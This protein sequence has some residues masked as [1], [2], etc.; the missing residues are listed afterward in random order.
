MVSEMEFATQI[1]VIWCMIL[2]SSGVINCGYSLT[3]HQGIKPINPVN[4]KGHY[5]D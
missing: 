1:L 2:I 3:A 5:R 4:Y